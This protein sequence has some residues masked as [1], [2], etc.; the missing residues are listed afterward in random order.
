MAEG[1]LFHVAYTFRGKRIGIISV[2]LAKP[3]ERTRYDEHNT[4]E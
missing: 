1:R 2:R 4:K 3:R